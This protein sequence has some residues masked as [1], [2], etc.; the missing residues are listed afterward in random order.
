MDMP[1]LLVLTAGLLMQSSETTATDSIGANLRILPRNQENILLQSVVSQAIVNAHRVRQLENRV[2]NIEQATINSPDD[3]IS[4]SDTWQITTKTSSSNY[5][6]GTPGDILLKIEGDQG[7][8]RTLRITATLEKGKTQK[9]EFNIGNDVG[10]VQKL[11]VE[12]IGNDGWLFE[13]IKVKNTRTQ[14]QYLFNYNDWIDGDDPD[15]PNTV[16][17]NAVDVDECGVTPPVCLHGG[18]CSNLMNRG[19]SCDCRAT[20]Y[21]GNTCEQD[22]NECQNAT[23]CKHGGKCTNTPGSYTCDCDGTGYQG[24]QCNID[25]NE[26]QNAT[27]CKHGGKCNNTA[28]SYTCDCDGTGFEGLTCN[29]GD[30]WRVLINTGNH[31][32]IDDILLQIRG[33]RFSSR[34]LRIT[35]DTRAAHTFN[36]IIDVGNVHSLRLE[37]L[38]NDSCFV[39]NITLRNT[40]T[41]NQYI[42]NFYDV[43]DINQQVVILYLDC[44]WGWTYLKASNICVKD[45]DRKGNYDSAVYEC[46]E[47][48]GHL[49]EPHTYK[50]NAQIAKFAGQGAFTW[51]GISEIVE[52]EWRYQS[53]NR[54]VK[55]ANWAT[56]RPL[57]WLNMTHCGV[58]VNDLDLFVTQ[59][60]W[61][62]RSCIEI[63]PIMCS[64]VKDFNECLA[65]P[66]LHNGNCSN[67]VGS[68]TCDC[69]NTGYTG[70]LCEKDIDECLN[71]TDPTPACQHGGVCTNTNGNFQCNCTG[72][73]YQ[74]K[75]C[76]IDI[77]ECLNSTD[78]TPACQHGGV[79]T[80]TNGSFQCNCTGTGYQGKTCQI[81]IDE[82]L[83]GVDPEP[84]CQH[85]GVCSNT[86]GSFICDCKGTGYEGNR[87]ENDVNECDSALLPCLNNGTCTNTKGNFTCKCAVGYSGPR[88]GIE[89]SD[90]D[91]KWLDDESVMP[92]T[93]IKWSKYPG[94][95][96]P[97]GDG[98][99]V[100]IILDALNTNWEFNDI[101]CNKELPF[102]CQ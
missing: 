34:Q 60:R 14:Y 3:K 70:T 85:D 21:R 54:S 49:P 2:T 8:T 94:G 80:N 5:Y 27:P 90:D 38:G 29:K 39:G 62:D 63:Y 73:G 100:T 4:S 13:S 59:G 71:S 96:N 68:F 35:L 83:N 97:N 89:G 102:V 45:I 86:N 37:L 93:G 32:C 9:F 51:L 30:T 91:F 74:G 12:L 65:K 42:F 55:Y 64:R 88:C 78:P 44:P 18:K 98:N 23:P 82:C 1:L 24:A 95:I 81:D 72:T 53:D 101:R 46:S 33:D 61:Y 26:C 84:A 10:N 48:G 11:R 52:G 57:N 77:D 7:D 25:I 75:T 50:E 47:N 43:L 99:C 56:G 67:T 31:I 22:I 19:F 76:Q 6:A 69:Q 87:C 66:C 20:G 16:T 40:R 36:D 79:C 17:L 41:G 58:L 28:G 15:Y 92:E